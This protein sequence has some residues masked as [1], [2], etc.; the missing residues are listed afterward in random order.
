MY[1]GDYSD[2]LKIEASLENGAEGAAVGLVTRDISKPR[3]LLLNTRLYIFADMWDIVGLK[4]LALRKFKSSLLP[5]GGLLN[6]LVRCLRLIYNQF[7]EKDHLKDCAL[8]L[9]A[10]CYADLVKR[11]DF[12][13]LCQRKGKIALD[14]L[15]GVARMAEKEKQEGNKHPLP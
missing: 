10:R 2:V 1:T 6:D 5:R 13:K 7:S 11:E 8:S 4:S 12:K 9:A 3:D 15:E 14:I